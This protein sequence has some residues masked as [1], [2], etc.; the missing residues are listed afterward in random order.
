MWLKFLTNLVVVAKY[1]H[2]AFCF[3]E[4]KAEAFPILET[5]SVY[6]RTADWYS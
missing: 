5:I 3:S 1:M 2:K 6:L 4:D